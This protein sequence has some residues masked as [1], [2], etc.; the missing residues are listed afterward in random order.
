MAQSAKAQ[1]SLDVRQ[2]LKGMPRADVL[3]MLNELAAG[4]AD[5]YPELTG[6]PLPAARV[7]CVMV[8]A[9]S[10]RVRGSR[11]AVSSFVNQRYRNRTLVVVNACGDDLSLPA[12]DRIVEVKHPPGSVG[13]L[14]NAGASVAS[15]LSGP[16]DDSWVVQWDDDDY[17]HPDRLTYQMLHRRCLNGVPVPVV[18]TRQLCINLTSGVVFCRHCPS[19]IART[20][21]VPLA[22]AGTYPDTSAGEDVLLLKSCVGGWVA[23]D[24]DGDLSRMVT[25]FYHGRNVTPAPEWLRGA[26]EMNRLS[27][28]DFTYFLEVCS[29]YGVKVN[30]KKTG[31]EVEAVD[32]EN[33]SPASI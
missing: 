30:E 33:V 2:L 25:A 17:P 28:A 15:D 21:M 23:A 11:H 7:F 13:S 31:L 18:L 12:D 10:A 16:L 6:T 1:A 3:A 8:V 22:L 27:H 5:S 20:A 19:G 24:N 26:G 9:D 32:R 29:L 14:R 4:E